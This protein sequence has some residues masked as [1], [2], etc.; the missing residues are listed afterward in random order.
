MLKSNYHITTMSDTHGQQEQTIHSRGVIPFGEKVALP[1]VSY[2]SSKLKLLISSGSSI[3]TPTDFELTI[4]L[5]DSSLEDVAYCDHFSAARTGSYYT[6]VYQRRENNSRT[7]VWAQSKNQVD[8]YV[9]DETSSINERAV[10]VSHFEDQPLILFGK[11]SLYVAKLSSKGP[12]AI[13]RC[14]TEKLSGFLFAGNNLTPLVAKFDQQGIFV[15]VDCSYRIDNETVMLQLGSLILDRS[16]PRKIIWSGEAPL[17]AAAYKQREKLQPLGAVINGASIHVYW[18][19]DDRQQITVIIPNPLYQRRRLERKKTDLIRRCQDNPLIEPMPGLS[20]EAAGTFNPG[21]ALIEGVVHMIYRAVGSDGISRFGYAASE[22][23]RKIDARKAEPVYT[24]RAAFEGGNGKPTPYYA[25]WQSGCGWGGCEDP[26][27]TVLEDRVYMTYVAHNGRSEPRCAM[28]SIKIDDFVNH[29][30]NWEEP[31]LISMPGEVNKSPCLL[32][33]KINGKYVMF[34]RVFP[35]ILID[36]MDDL[37]FGDNKKWLQGHNMISTRPDMWD[38]RKLS[39][40]APPIKTD[41]GWLIIYHAVDDRDDTRYK[42]GAMIVDKEDLSNVL[43]RT[44]YPMINP[45]MWYENDWKPGIVYPSGA[46]VKD[47]RLLVYYGGGDKT[48]CLL[49]TNLDEFLENL[50]QPVHHVCSPT[51]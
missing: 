20:W 49:E 48:V 11:N 27:L 30:W 14:S 3:L 47:N 24:P 2:A 15:L 10:I 50:T 31:Q 23:G 29:D 40:G 43:W 1:Y 37:S 19:F 16:N 17:F 45:D 51:V 8:W 18:E 4:K 5:P 34:H 32:S 13:K 41:Y 39:V 42:A 36:Y 46:V 28:T 25:Q 12:I 26:K 33:E 9:Q 44:K 6:M 22:D 35:N 21:V 38:S 7:T